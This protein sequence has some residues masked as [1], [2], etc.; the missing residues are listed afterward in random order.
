MLKMSHHFNGFILAMTLMIIAPDFIRGQEAK[1][2]PLLEPGNFVFQADFSLNPAIRPGPEGEWDE[3]YI[4]SGDLVKIGDNYYWYYHGNKNTYQIGVAFEKVPSGPY[5][6]WEKSTRNPIL[7][8]DEL[9]FAAGKI[10]QKTF[11]ITANVRFIKVLV[12]NIDITQS[13]SDVSITATVGG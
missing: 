2:I 8:K 11:E 12:E 1:G 7:G 13:V 9:S 6:S 3:G 4:E 10:I 5:A